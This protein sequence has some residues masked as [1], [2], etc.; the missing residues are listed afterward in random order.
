MCFMLLSTAKVISAKLEN[1]S[2][3]KF[4]SFKGSLI[5]E[6]PWIVLHNATRHIYSNE[7]NPLMVFQRR[8]MPLSHI[9]DVHTI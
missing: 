9:K 4:L 6:G 3:K 1:G 8:L 7:A 5:A 2:S